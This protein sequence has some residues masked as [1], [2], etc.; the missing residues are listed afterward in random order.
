MRQRT[1]SPEWLIRKIVDGQPYPLSEPRSLE[2]RI[3][4][5]EMVVS[6]MERK[7]VACR[8]VIA[9]IRPV[10]EEERAAL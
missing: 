9:A 7:I 8:E 3:H 5:Y 10:L 6:D 2:E 4:I 1:K